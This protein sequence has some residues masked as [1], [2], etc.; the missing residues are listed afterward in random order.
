MAQRFIWPIPVQVA[1]H[2]IILEDM[3]LLVGVKDAVGVTEIVVTGC[4]CDPDTPCWKPCAGNQFTLPSDFLDVVTRNAAMNAVK[5]KVVATCELTPMKRALD[6]EKVM[7]A[8]I[9]SVRKGD[10]QVGKFP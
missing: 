9:A 4:V 3:A 6:T 10:D 8:C 1:K 7:T 5:P 2:S